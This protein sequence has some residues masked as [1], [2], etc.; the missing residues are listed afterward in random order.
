MDHVQG[1]VVIEGRFGWADLGSW[2]V[3]ARASRGAAEH[4]GV[5]G[6]SVQV[7]S[8]EPHLVATIG[9]GELLVVRT[10]SATLICRPKQAQQVRQ[11]V[12]LLSADPRLR[13]YV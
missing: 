4:V 12:Q 10:K 3:W 9:V 13:A 2:D 1:G 8:Q 6:G 7:V 11:I 5:G